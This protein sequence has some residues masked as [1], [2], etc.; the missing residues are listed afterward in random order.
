MCIRDSLYIRSVFISHTRIYNIYYISLETTFLDFLLYFK[1]LEIH[2]RYN[3]A[4]RTQSVSSF[5]FLSI[6]VKFFQVCDPM[7]PYFQIS[8]SLPLLP[9]AR[10]FSLSFSWFLNVF[11]FYFM[12][13]LNQF[14][15]PIYIL[16]DIINWI[17]YDILIIKLWS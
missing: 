15:V 3:Y 8:I 2:Y 6:L 13:L 12:S 16:S 1:Y 10:G 7:I 9:Q 11:Y 14:K 5:Q 17:F 4:V